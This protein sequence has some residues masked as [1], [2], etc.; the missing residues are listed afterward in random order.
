MS[1]HQQQQALSP[2][3][4]IRTR[5]RTLSIG[6]CYINSNWRESGL[7]LVFVNRRHINA[8]VTHAAYVVDLYCLG[9]KESFWTFNQDPLDFKDFMEQQQ[10]ENPQGVRLIKTEYGLVHNIIYGAIEYAGE[11]GFLPHKSFDT[12][13]YVLEEDDDHVEF[14]KLTFGYKGKPL[15]ISSPGQPAERNRVLA[16]LEKNPGRGK[17]EYITEA[18]APVFFENADKKEREA[19]NYHDPEVKQGIIT[20]FIARTGN[21][22]QFMLNKVELIGEILRLSEAIF[23]EYM[24]SDEEMEKSF[25]TISDLFDFE[26]TDESFS[27]EM[28]LWNNQAGENLPEIRRQAEKLLF[29]LE[30]GQ[31]T[32]GLWQSK[33]MMDKYPEF[34]VFI[35]LYMSF[36]EQKDGLIKLLSKLEKFTI[37]YP[38]Y[39]P[40]TYL[41]A[42][43]FLLNK[44][45][46][47]SRQ[48]DDSFHLKNFYPHRKTFCKEEVLD[49]V[50]LLSI[51]YSHSGKFALNEEI[52]MHFDNYFPGVIPES[53]I[54][55]LKL[56]KIPHVLEWCRKWMEEQ[57]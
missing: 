6:T 5:A 22:E 34:P 35:Y 31:V 8:H 14:I 11:L 54:L 36:L 26:I 24:R 45:E 21:P 25:E 18:D 55:T 37:Q 51:N 40:L 44:P 33:V 56:Q 3:K 48:I 42:V 19:A 29:M 47:T 16:Q 57:K 17:Y 50:T 13:K 43:S 7:A 9:L 23:Y 30:E 32:D 53:Q 27:D 38:D 2:E 52:I 15:Y 41:Y 20:D 4:Y 49:Y 10:K 1:K 46:G 12:T 39:L 28:L